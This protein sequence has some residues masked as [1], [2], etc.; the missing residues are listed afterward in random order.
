[1]LVS[2]V[3]INTELMH[4]ILLILLTFKIMLTLNILVGGPYNHVVSMF[5]D[6]S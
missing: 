6:L 3:F 2:V 5:D 1:M 4:C